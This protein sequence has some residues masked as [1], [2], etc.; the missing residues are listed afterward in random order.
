M[1]SIKKELE[2]CT[3]CPKLCRFACP[4][5]NVEYRESV[6]PWGKVGMLYFLSKDYVPKTT[7]N[8]ELIYH[9]TGCLSC[10][11]FCEHQI[12]VPD[13]LTHGRKLAYE[14][15]RHHKRLE[16]GLKNIK[17]VG[18]IFKNDLNNKI[19][20]EL[21]AVY[22]STSLKAKIFLGC[23]YT[24][25]HVEKIRKVIFILE[26]LGIDY[27]GI[28]SNK[29]FCCGY[30]LYSS[31]FEKEFVNYIIKIKNNLSGTK[32][33]IALCPTCAYT[34]KALY[35]QYDNGI[36]AEVLTFSEF[37]LPFVKAMARNKKKIT[38][39]YSYHDPCFMSRY[40]NQVSEPRELITTTGA[41]LSE[42]LWSKKNSVCCGGGGMFRSTN[43][44]ISLDMAYKRIEEFKTIGSKAIA[45]SCPTCLNMFKDA[46]PD[47]EV[48]DIIDVVH[49]FIN[50]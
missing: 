12:S 2:Y 7:E 36:K 20:S 6:T 26:R 15:S 32:K 22:F 4:V 39:H 27:V 35:Q 9:C 41:I 37:I 38:E 43:K 16:K 10:R 8:Y 24:E 18:S 47:I 28:Y 23:V 1:R 21:D 14:D 30:P 5:A 50:Q 42:F 33:L 48:I 19:R 34:L 29:E 31:G 17:K 13:I 25:K 44:V 45:T 3:T 46:D 49:N 40:L 11:E